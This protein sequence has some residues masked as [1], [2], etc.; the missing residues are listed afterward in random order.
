MSSIKTAELNLVDEYFR[1]DEKGYV[2]DFSNRTMAEFFQLEFDV[3]LYGGD[4]EGEGRSKAARL[5]CFL[6]T[7]DDSSAANVL[8]RLM[9][10][11]AAMARKPRTNSRP[12]AEGQILAIVS[13]LKS[14]NETTGTPP[15]PVFNRI[16]FEALRDRLNQMWDMDAHPRGYAFEAYLKDLFDAFQLKARRPFS[17]VGEQ[18]DGSFE[19]KGEIYLL[20]AKW[21][22]EQ[23]GSNELR[24]FQGKVEDKAAWTRGLF[25]SFGGFTDVGLQ[26]FGRGRKVVCLEGRDIYEA[27]DRNIPID[28]M[29]DRKVRWA[30]ETGQPFIPVRELYPPNG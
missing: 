21:A 22:K 7:V 6:K 10:Y 1:G 5:R 18:I 13:R 2:L 4:Y 12:L 3:D 24:S 25:V 23:I 29:L 20:E 8:K 28:A 30:A 15:A 27:L 14:G 9:N 11:R 19:L 17:L 26:A 16:K